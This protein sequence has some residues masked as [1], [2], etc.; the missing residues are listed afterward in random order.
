MAW[1]IMGAYGVMYG[2]S[3]EWVRTE[4]GGGMTILV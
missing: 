2:V 1:D 3:T 4:G